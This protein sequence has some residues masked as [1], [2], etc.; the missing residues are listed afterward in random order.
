MHEPGTGHPPGPRR[1]LWTGLAGLA[2]GAAAM[3]GIWG[4]ASAHVSAPSVTP[5]G[6]VARLDGETITQH[7][8]QAAVLAQYGTQT[9]EQLIE[10]RLIAD[11]AKEDHVTATATEMESAEAGIEAQYG[12]SGSAELAAF[13]AQQGLTPAEFQQILKN[14][15]LEEQVA[16]HGIHVSNAAITAYYKAHKAQFTPAGAKQPQP[17][18]RVRSTIVTDLRESE[19]PAPPALLAALAKRYHLTLYG[20]YKAVGAAIEHPAGS[21]AP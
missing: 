17:L 16:L 20:S 5:S 2:V 13:L 6:A 3:A 18:S 7:D 14:E 21:S 8:L 10:T 9:L 1:G 19:A 12:I 4:V 15:V 11:A